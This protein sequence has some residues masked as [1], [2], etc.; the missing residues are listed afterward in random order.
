MVAKRLGPTIFLLSFLLVAPIVPPSL[1]KDAI[2]WMEVSMP[3][4]F[5]QEGPDKNQGYGDVISAILQEH[6]PE[7]DHFEMV[8]NVTRHF[9]KFQKGEKVC[10]VGLYRTPE[11]EA[12]MYFSIPSFLTLPSV[13]IVSKETAADLGSPSS[14]RLEE[15]LRDKRFV[16]GLSKDRSYGTRIDAI[17]AQH[18]DSANTI[19]YTGQELSANYF[20]MLML[21]RIDGLIALPDEAM[22]HAEKMGLR[23][24]LTTLIIEEN[25][26]GYEGWLCSVGCPKNEWGRTVID[27][28]NTILREQ[29]PTERYRGA[30]ERWLDANSLE[31]YRAVYRDVFLTSGTEERSPAAPL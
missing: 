9:H 14:I 26:E 24:R 18:K 30:Y 6:L 27:K 10:S 1:A 15:I 23:D 5:I 25:Q 11:R 22:Y 28:I 31:R 2:T 20:K 21:K 3:P 16:V 4:Y 13:L 8:T 29:R 19:L 7:Y 12:F 17:L